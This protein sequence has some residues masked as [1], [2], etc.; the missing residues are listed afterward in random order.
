MKKILTNSKF[1]TVLEPV[2]VLRLLGNQQ[3]QTLGRHRDL[4]GEMRGKHWPTWARKSQTPVKVQS[5]WLL[6]RWSLVRALAKECEAQGYRQ[7]GSMSSC[8]QFSMNSTV[9]SQKWLGESAES[10]PCGALLEESNRSCCGRQET[11]SRTFSL[12][13]K[14]LHLCSMCV[15]GD[16][17]CHP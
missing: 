12:M 17:H 2:G 11:P 8:R 4:Q 9:S 15:E 5:T 6:N 13:N 7:R 14:S 10:L 3:A 16:L 1:S